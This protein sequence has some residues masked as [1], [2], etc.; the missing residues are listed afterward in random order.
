MEK[1]SQSNGRR[2][3]L[4][5]TVSF[6][7]IEARASETKDLLEKERSKTRYFKKHIKMYYNPI[8]RHSAHDM[9]SPVE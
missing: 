4:T 1:Q 5:K 9:L 2:F 3:T 7:A 8:R 6:P